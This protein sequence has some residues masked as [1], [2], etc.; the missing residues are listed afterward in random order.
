MNMEMSRQAGDHCSYPCKDGHTNSNVSFPSHNGIHLRTLEFSADQTHPH[1]RI[2]DQG[3]MSS[4][5]GR[6]G[7]VENSA[8]GHLE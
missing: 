1:P 3:S 6:Y 5:G 7:Q 4:H 8:Q 2:F